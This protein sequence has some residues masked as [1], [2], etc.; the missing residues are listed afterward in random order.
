MSKECFHH[1]H[2]EKAEKAKIRITRRELDVIFKTGLS[3]ILE[4]EEAGNT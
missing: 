4:L 3:P 1:F 2:L